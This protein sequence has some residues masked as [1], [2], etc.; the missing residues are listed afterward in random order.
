[1]SGVPA[2]R[3]DPRAGGDRVIEGPPAGE[4]LERVRA[5]RFPRL[6]SMLLRATRE[7]LAED[8][9]A[10]ETRLACVVASPELSLEEAARHVLRA[11]GKRA[12]PV[13][14]CAV[15]RARGGDP[16]RHLDAVAA[17]E[18]AHAGS[19]L[20]DDI[21]DGA[22]MRR[23]R[24]A[25]HLLFEVPT[26]ILAGD[27][28]LSIAFEWV[29]SGPRGLWPRF[30]AAVRDVC[31]GE[32]LERESLCDPTI[33]LSRVR[34]INR[35][36]TGALFRYAAEA[37][38][39]LAGGDPQVVAAARDYGS[40]LGE[41][42]QLA[43]DLLDF[44]GTPVALGKPVGMDLAAGCVTAPLALALERDPTLGDA[45]VDLWWSPNGRGEQMLPEIHARIARTG[46]FEATRALA[47]ECA[48]AAQASAARLATGRWRDQLATFAEEV[49]RRAREI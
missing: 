11:G 8:L 43:D 31:T 25:A 46:A 48:E 21:I 10:I 7:E 22:R 1:V 36:K 4:T 24:P 37:G 20:H 44:R 28:L 9:A 18:L 3:P 27:V 29:A 16:A 13:L 17:V 14:S 6:D 30:S 19:L 2:T 39:I 34:R 32:A 49:A 12:R 38:A 15:L 35:L 33:G 40:A 5:S 23:G 42:F 41:A 45:V 26:T 47:T